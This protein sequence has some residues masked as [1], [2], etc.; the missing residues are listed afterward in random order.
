MPWVTWALVTG[1]RVTGVKVTCSR[2]GSESLS[3]LGSLRVT[4]VIRLN[5]TSGV[6]V[7]WVI[8]V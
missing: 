8:G 7:T 5:G 4:G 1:V 3:S 6:R 2:W